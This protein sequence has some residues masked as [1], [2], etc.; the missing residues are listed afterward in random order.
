MRSA[1]TSGTNSGGSTSSG[2]TIP[3]TN[4]TGN[5]YGLA[6]APQS[7]FQIT[8]DTGTARSWSPGTAFS[9]ETKLKVKISP[10]PATNITVPGYNNWVFPY[11]CMS[12]Q[13]TVNGST[14]TTVPLKVPGMV[15]SPGSPCANASGIASTRFL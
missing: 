6:P 14:Q 9:S 1:A 11:G 15:Q 8:G 13:V 4:P 10:L 3:S 7:M 12:V 5:I 2:T